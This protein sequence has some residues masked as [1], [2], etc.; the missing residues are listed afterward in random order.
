MSVG[1]G[2]DSIHFSMVYIWRESRDV[3]SLP[4]YF[5]FSVAPVLNQLRDLYTGTLPAVPA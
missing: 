2:L 5:G 1:L 4:T 3:S